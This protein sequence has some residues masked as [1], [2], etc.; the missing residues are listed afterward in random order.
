MEDGKLNVWLSPPE[1]IDARMATNNV[2]AMMV[3]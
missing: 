1:I 3:G 2:F